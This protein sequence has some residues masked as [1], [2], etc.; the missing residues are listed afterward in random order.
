MFV[1]NDLLGP[2]EKI[3]SFAQKFSKYT[4]ESYKLFLEVY[5]NR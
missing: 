5:Y 3:L 2:N 4:V 1:S